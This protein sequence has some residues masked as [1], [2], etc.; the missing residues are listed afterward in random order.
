[1]KVEIYQEKK[2]SFITKGFVSSLI[3][4]IKSSRTISYMTEWERDHSTERKD[5]D[6]KIKELNDMKSN[7]LKEIDESEFS[8]IVIEIKLEK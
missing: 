1:M 2:D 7:L 3:N 8:N 4:S 5:L 6:V